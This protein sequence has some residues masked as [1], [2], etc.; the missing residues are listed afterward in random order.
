MQYGLRPRRTIAREIKLAAAAS[1]TLQSCSCTLSFCLGNMV[2]TIIQ[3]R[4]VALVSASAWGTRHLHLRRGL[5]LDR[6]GCHRRCTRPRRECAG[7][8]QKRAPAVARSPLEE[9]GAVLPKRRGADALKALVASEI[10]KW[11]PIIK[12]AGPAANHELGD[13]SRP[14]RDHRRTVSPSFKARMRKPSCFS[15]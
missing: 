3:R 14:L 11:T 7:A 12:A 1:L 8:S 2:S 6:A 10:E 5:P 9:I 4:G 15:S 13:Q